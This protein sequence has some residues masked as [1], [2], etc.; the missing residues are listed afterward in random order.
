MRKTGLRFLR[1]VGGRTVVERASRDL[2]KR[3]AQRSLEARDTAPERLLRRRLVA[4]RLATRGEYAGRNFSVIRGGGDS[5]RSVGIYMKGSCDLP[6]VFACTPLIRPVLAGTCCT[7]RDGVVADGHSQLLL[8]SLRGLPPEWLDP[9]RTHLKL[10]RQFDPGAFDPS[11]VVPGFENL[12]EFPKSVVVLSILADVTRTLYRHREH[13][14]VVDPG[15]WWLTQDMG[16]VLENL[17]RAEWFRGNFE[18]VGKIEVEEFHQTLGEVVRSFQ[19]KAGAHVLVFNALVVEPGART[20]NY[21]FVKHSPGRRRREFNLALAE[22]SAEL[23]FS[24]VDVD[25]VL[26]RSGIS[27][28]VDFAHFPLE[29]VEEVAAEVFGILRE[30]EVV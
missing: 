8:Q 29:K 7:L 14:F 2:Y 6:A 3:W 13:G 4:L 22:L 17:E 11:F 18:K 16:N 20:H 15:G 24:V 25:R 26:K 5:G 23:G 28:Q 27:T 9:V 21:Q 30:R 12:G 19:E 1:S 10:S